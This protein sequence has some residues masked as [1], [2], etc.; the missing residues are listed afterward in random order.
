MIS[1]VLTM[2]LTIAAQAQPVIEAGIITGTIVDA[3]DGLPMPGAHVIVGAS[4]FSAVSDQ[5]GTFIIRKIPAGRY[6]MAVSYLGYQHFEMQVQVM[7][8]QEKTLTIRLQPAVLTGEEVVVLGERLKG[9]AKALSQQQFNPNV[10]NVVAADQIG[11]FPDGNAGDALKRIPGLVVQ[12]DMGEARFGLIRGT[13]PRYNAIL[14]NGERMPSSEGSRRDL[15]LDLIPADLLQTIE[16]NKSLTPDMDADAIGGSVNLITRAAPHGTRVSTTLGSGYNV[17][18][19]KPT[20]L[21]NLIYGTRVSD[22]KLG[23]IFSGSYFNHRMGADNVE[24]EWDDQDGRAFLADHQI[25]KYDVQRIRYGATAAFDYSITPHSTIFLRTTYNLRDDF[26]NRFRLRYRLDKGEDDGMPDA[27]GLVTGARVE[28]Q[29]K[30]GAPGR[31]REARLE[32]SITTNANLAGTH[33][34]GQRLQIDWS[35]AWAYARENRPDEYYVNFRLDDVTLMPQIEDPEFVNVGFVDPEDVGAYELREFEVEHRFTDEYDLN[36]RVDVAWLL[37]S[38]ADRKSQLKSGLRYRGKVKMRENDF[39]VYESTED[40][41][42]AHFTLRDNTDPNYLAGDYALGVFPTTDDLAHFRDRYSVEGTDMP[43][44]YAGGNYEAKERISAGYLM[45]TRQVGPQLSFIAGVRVEDT[46]LDYTGNELHYNEDGDLAGIQSRGDTG[47]YF[48]VLPGL[49]A[50]FNLDDDTILRLA[51]TRSL[52]RPNYYD[53]VPYRI[54]NVEDEEL[55]EGNPG[56][57]PSV[58][59][60]LDFTAERYLSTV[61]IF[62]AGLFYKQID[63]FTYLFVIDDYVDPLSGQGFSE[64]IQPRNGNGASL[65]GLEVAAQQQ[66]MFLP[67]LLRRF[68]LYGNY[69]FTTSTVE[70]MPNRD[71]PLPSLPG[72][73]RHSYNLSVVYD[74]EGFSARISLNHHSSHIEEVGDSPENDVYYQAATYVDA[75]ASYAVRSGLRVFLEANNLTNQPLRYYQ[76]SRSRNI[77]TEYYQARFQLGLKYDL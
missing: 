61:G 9:Q 76:G 49:N 10:T 3:E 17:L 46:W 35:G 5:K 19:G 52:A 7:P 50:R 11:R 72:S 64:F 77:Q 4:G 37:N 44:E 67:G 36:W 65:F 55:S 24:F 48:N 51:A 25:R 43:E 47:R 14:I 29:V 16:V 1:V 2:V 58:S 59:T 12:N 45:L 60:N 73:S 69:T 39:D 32:R 68:G 28:R 21:A 74:W 18:S 27:D 54:I 26:E 34:V 40:L 66:L 23:M 56:L 71:E 63:D 20:G 22:G 57:D 13:A 31:N 42:L 53:L 30:G 70:S 62:S 38:E 75:N 41:S 8:E 15:S 6:P 33:L